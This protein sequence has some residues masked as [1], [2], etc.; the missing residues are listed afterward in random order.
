VFQIAQSKLKIANEIKSRREIEAEVFGGNRLA[1]AKLVE[2]LE[3]AAINLQTS[4]SEK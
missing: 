3:Q 1:R 2:N 4:I